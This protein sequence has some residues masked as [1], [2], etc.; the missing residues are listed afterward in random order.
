[1]IPSDRP[2]LLITSATHE[3][4]RGKNNE[5]R[6]GVSVLRTGK[7]ADALPV[8]FAVLCDG[9]GGHRAGEVAAEIAV[10]TVSKAVAAADPAQQKPQDVLQE[11]IQ[12]ASQ[13]IRA[14]AEGDSGRKGMGS[15]CVCAWVIGDR[16][17]SAY[18]GDSRLFM[19]RDGQ[20]QQMTIDHTWVQ[21]AI[22]FGVL[23]P[24][25]ARNHPN[26]H[27]IRR[28][29]GSQELPEVDFRL[30]LSTGESDEQS[31]ANQGTRLHPGD[32]L[33]LCSDGLSDLVAA[34][35]VLEMIQKE[36]RQRA[37]Q[38]LVELANERG[39]HD[40][41][42]IVLLEFPAQAAAPTELKTAP[43]RTRGAAP[44]V[45]SQAAGAPAA[46]PAAP[47][48]PRQR[49]A[50]QIGIT[51]AVAAVGGLVILLIAAALGWYLNSTGAIRLPW[52]SGPTQTP[53]ATAPVLTP[54]AIEFPTETP[55][56]G[57]L[58]TDALPGAASGSQPTATATATVAP[59]QATTT[60]WPTNTVEPTPS[61]T[62]PPQAAPPRP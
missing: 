2:H 47:A 18:V 30:R 15:T 25:Q 49:M 32:I 3:G 23:T 46:A 31:I 61:Q 51:C 24:E 43:L 56:A 16:L 36:T 39:G 19:I 34:D 17:Y 44:T 52:L 54:P 21:E 7:A 58:P 62:E 55:P 4:M 57:A 22:E 6:Y 37:P 28:Y 9:I 20:I 42:T 14:Q 35:E 27:V 29:L 40:N 33:L 59:A 38:A 11:G 10:E 26:A 5:D 41:I 60:P 12:K 48:A 13:T 1:M 50:R 53:T 8:V 45:I